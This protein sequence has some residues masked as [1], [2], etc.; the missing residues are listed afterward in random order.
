MIEIFTKLNFNSYKGFVLP[1]HLFP[2]GQVRRPAPDP[3]SYLK[4]PGSPSWQLLVALRCTI[5]ML[6]GTVEEEGGGT[7]FDMDFGAQK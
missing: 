1:R 5:S 4:E 7:I 3:A 6:R 2:L